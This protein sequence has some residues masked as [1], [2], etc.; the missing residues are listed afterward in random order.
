MKDTCNYKTCK[1]AKR[2]RL[3]SREECPNFVEN[4]WIP[5][6][7]ERSDAIELKDC[8]PK[9]TLLC[10]QDLYARLIGVEKSQEHQTNAMLPLNKMLKAMRLT[11]GLKILPPGEPDEVK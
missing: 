1:V 6:M 2:M 10:V 9:R 8:A 4:S 11:E 5:P 3:K 7:K